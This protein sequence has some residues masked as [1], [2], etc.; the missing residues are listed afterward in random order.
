[1]SVGVCGD[2]QAVIS[3][4]LTVLDRHIPKGHVGL[5]EH[6]EDN[7]RPDDERT[8]FGGDGDGEDNGEDNDQKR[9]QRSTQKTLL[10]M[11]EKERELFALSAGTQLK[12]VFCVYSTV[13]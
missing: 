8:H 1:M 13:E 9:T 6:W 12:N 5:G 10:L 11:I 3:V 4:G 2:G 7:R